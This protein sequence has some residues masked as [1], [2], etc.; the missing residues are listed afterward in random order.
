MNAVYYVMK[1][2]GAELRLYHLTLLLIPIILALTFTFQEAHKV[3]YVP[4]SFTVCALILFANFPGIVVMLHS[5][6]IYYDDLVIRSYNEEDVPVIYD[7]A[8]CKKYQKIFRWLATVTSALMVSLTAEMWFYRDRLFSGDTDVINSLAALGIIAGILRI[9]YSITM[10]LGRLIMFVLKVL[11]KR[12]QEKI[13]R[14]TE[15][16]TLID[17]NNIGIVIRTSDD[18]MKEEL[19]THTEDHQDFRQHVILKDRAMVD[20]FN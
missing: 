15:Q 16:R 13:L 19:I 12:E 17:L 4:F 5:R 10:T 9:Y 6:P 3:I 11:Q 7:D 1:V 18:V 20:L 8:F 14:L 2:C